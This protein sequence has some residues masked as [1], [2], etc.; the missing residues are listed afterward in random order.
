MF[1][2]YHLPKDARSVEKKDPVLPL[3]DTG[4]NVPCCGFEGLCYVD[5]QILAR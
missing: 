1:G 4:S 3:K 5:E 2:W